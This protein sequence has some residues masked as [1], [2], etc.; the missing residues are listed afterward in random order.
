MREPQ[1]KLA[2]AEPLAYS[3]TAQISTQMVQLVLRYTGRGPTKARTTIDP[4]FV[5]IVLDDTLT[6]SE[7]SL[8]AAG[9]EDLIRQQ[10]SRLHELMR[11]EATEIV[12]RTVGRKVRSLLGD[13]S[14][15]EGVA[16][17]VFLL[18]QVPEPGISG[19]DGDGDGAGPSQA[20]GS[21]SSDG[22]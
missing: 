17:V 19:V 18:E 10:R 12:E 20:P 6:R 11:G 16:V 14:P 3:A 2:S 15:A 1:R 13:V 7:R 21:S 9:E 4:N 8:L 5:L 22:R